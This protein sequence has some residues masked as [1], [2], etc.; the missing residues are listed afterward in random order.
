MSKDYIIARNTEKR[1]DGHLLD[2][3]NRSGRM[4]LW[5]DYNN[6]RI[7]SLSDRLDAGLARLEALRVR[8]P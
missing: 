5:L 3:R 1:M 8:T 6:R 7:A 2:A 4:Q